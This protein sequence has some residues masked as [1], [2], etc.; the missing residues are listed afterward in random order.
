MKKWG[1]HPEFPLSWVPAGLPAFQVAAM[2]CFLHFYLSGEISSQCSVPEFYQGDVFL[3]CT[4]Q[5]FSMSMPWWWPNNWLMIT[6]RKMAFKWVIVS[7]AF[8]CHLQTIVFLVS[9]RLLLLLS[10]SY[11]PYCF[12]FLQS[13][14]KKGLGTGSSPLVFPV[15]GLECNGWCV[16]RLGALH[17]HHLYIHHAPC[18]VEF[19]LYDPKACS[20]CCRKI[21]TLCRSGMLISWSQ[22]ST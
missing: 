2:D 10:I 12:R 20:P 19:W 13:P 5:D 15:E 7:T 3:I 8:L 17:G 14:W 16:H 21:T 11:C 6:R 22:N 18:T 4:Q 9:L 1:A